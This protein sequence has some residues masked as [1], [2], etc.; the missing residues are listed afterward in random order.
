MERA[1]DGRRLGLVVVVEA[2]A[3]ALKRGKQDKIDLADLW[4]ACCEIVPYL[5]HAC[6][7]DFGDDATE[8]FRKLELISTTRI[9]TNGVSY[10]LSFFCM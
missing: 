10:S 1:D 5:C 3:A 6:F 2:L 9:F 7:R 8:M 4:S